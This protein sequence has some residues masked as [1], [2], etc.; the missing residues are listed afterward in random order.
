MK[1]NKGYYHWIHALNQT[2]SYNQMRADKILTE[3]KAVKITDKAKLETLGQQLK[4]VVP[5]SHG[6]PDID[7]AAVRMFGQQLA[8]TG[9]VTAQS[10]TKAGGDAGA[11]IS[12]QQMKAAQDA[13]MRA[14]MQGPIDAAPEGD[15]Q[16]VE[17]DA[18]DG[19]LEDPPLTTLPSYSL[20][21]Q[22]RSENARQT[23]KEQSRASRVAERQASSEASYKAG[24]E[25]EQENIQGIVDR[26]MRG[27]R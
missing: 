1:N 10:I 25:S 20:A 12:L 17:D 8:K 18:Q 5:I 16:T 11:F 21:S 19:V 14:K 4:P 7:P 6:K 26:L 15:A 3:A 27:K 2:A 13:A 22:A 23:W 9:P 24:Q